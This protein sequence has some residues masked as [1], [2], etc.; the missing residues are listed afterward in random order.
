MSL[1]TPKIFA[2]CIA[3]VVGP[4]FAILVYHYEDLKPKPVEASTASG[5]V[6]F[7][8]GDWCGVCQRVKPVVS[9]LR[10]EGFDIR[11]VNVDARQDQA[12]S[13]GIRG[14]PTFV[15]IRDGHE[16]R[17]QVGGVSA[18]QLRNLWQ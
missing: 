16:V 10:R 7:F 15:L 4:P 14:I 13:Y 1:F 3:L 8:T 17:R 18:D 12:Q 9:Q 2:L 11:T 6:L 5:H